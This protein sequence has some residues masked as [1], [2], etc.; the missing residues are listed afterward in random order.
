MF[1]NLSHHPCRDWSHE[2]LSAAN[3]LASPIADYSFP[4]VPPDWGLDEV[5]HLADETVAA[6]KKLGASVVMI[7]GEST[8][9]Y[10]LVRN[11][12]TSAITCYA[13]TTRRVAETF[14]DAAGISIKQSRFEFVRFRR[15]E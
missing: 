12:A 2:Q 9:A 4:E 14:V 15:Y 5:R 10:W 8:L 7:Q 1:V 13:A 6:V 3:A 11:F